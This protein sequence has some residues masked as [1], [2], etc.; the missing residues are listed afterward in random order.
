MDFLISHY[1]VQHHRYS[2]VS[3]PPRL[4]AWVSTV[5][6]RP[7]HSSSSILDTHFSHSMS[8]QMSFLNFCTAC[9]RLFRPLTLKVPILM[10]SSCGFFSPPFYLP[11]LAFP[12]GWLLSFLRHRI[13]F[14]MGLIHFLLAVSG[15]SLQ[16][17]RYF[18]LDVLYSYCSL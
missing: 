4:Q 1:H 2:P 6:S 3:P 5:S 14:L 16:H 15:L 17:Y 8:M 10:L 7:S 12:L 18:R 13:L 9:S 11:L